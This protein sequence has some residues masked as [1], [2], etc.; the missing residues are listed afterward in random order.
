MKIKFLKTMF[1]LTLCTSLLT[2]CVGDDDFGRLNTDRLKADGV[3]VSAIK[4]LKTNVTGSAF[5]TYKENAERDFIFN[6]TKFG[7]I[8]VW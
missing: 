2:S 3:D 7:R 4:T 5:V 6:I 1:L 8:L